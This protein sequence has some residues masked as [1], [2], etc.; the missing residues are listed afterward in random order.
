MNYFSCKK[1]LFF[2]VYC[3]F[4]Y[5]CDSK[6]SIFAFELLIKQSK[7]SKHPLTTIILINKRISTV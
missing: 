4:C 6:L 2:T 7:E 1:R 3:S 5:T